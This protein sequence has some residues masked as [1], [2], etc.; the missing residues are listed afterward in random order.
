M[1]GPIT[2]GCQC[3]A[4]RYELSADPLGLYACHCTECQKQSSSAFGM[5]MPVARDGFRVVKGEPKTWVRASDSGRTV[6]CH[7]CGDCGTRLFHERAPGFLN[8]KAGT[9]DDT[10]GLRPVGNL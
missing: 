10:S 9:L 4:V 6:T 1:A 7:F 3:G 5:S 8:V 2:G